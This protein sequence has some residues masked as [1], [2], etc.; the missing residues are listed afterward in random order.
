MRK[1]K[2]ESKNIKKKENK[3]DIPDDYIEKIEKTFEGYV[4]YASRKKLT[5]TKKHLE[6]FLEG[7]GEEIKYP[8]EEARDFS[9]IQKGEKVNETRFLNSFKNKKSKIGKKLTSLKENDRFKS[10]DNWDYKSSW[11]S[12]NP[13]KNT[14]IKDGV[15]AKG[16]FGTTNLNSVINFEAIRKNDIVTLHGEINHTWRDKYDFEI[17]G[18]GGAGLTS[19][20]K[21]GKAKP[22]RFGSNWKKKFKTEY[23]IENNEL[24]LINH[25]IE[26]IEN[27]K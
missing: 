3:R 5:Y 22:F 1:T 25:Q 19:L 23:K 12:L 18:I 16:A 26:D 6:H 11:K 8:K 9:F 17:F 13:H 21:Y 14:I 24:K 15:D 10:T 7:S 20:E 4:D 2:P 27:K